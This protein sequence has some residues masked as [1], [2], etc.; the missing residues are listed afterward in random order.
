MLLTE[1]ST[2]EGLTSGVAC[3][4]KLRRPASH[5][6]HHGPLSPEIAAGLLAPKARPVDIPDGH[7]EKWRLSTAALAD[8]KFV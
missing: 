8:F 7:A 1:C 4:Y 6:M 3:F 5:V 2:Q